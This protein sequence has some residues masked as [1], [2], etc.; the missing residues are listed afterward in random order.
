MLCKNTVSELYGLKDI[1]IIK[2]ELEVKVLELRKDEK[3][4]LARNDIKYA[5]KFNQNFSIL[6]SKIVELKTFGLNTEQFEKIMSRYK[7]LFF[8]IVDSN[9]EIGLN[10]KSGL[11]G[12][13]RNS[14]HRFEEEFK[15]LKNYELLTDM[16]TLRRNE[17]DFMLRWDLKYLDKFEKNYLKTKANVEK[18]FLSN[19]KELLGYLA[20]YR[21]DFLKFV[22][23]SEA[24]GLDEKSGEMGQLRDI[25]H[26]SDE[27]LQGFVSE[28]NKI[29]KD[30]I[31]SKV[32]STVII[33]SIT[34]IVVIL[35]ILLI[36]KNIMSVIH[37]IQKD[38]NYIVNNRDFTYQLELK[39]KNEISDVVKSINILILAFKDVINSSKI[40]SK[41]TLESTKE[42]NQTSKVMLN[43]TL[44]QSEFVET[45]H[46]LVKD[47]GTNLD[48]TE[49]MIITTAEDL[50]STKI[51]LETFVKNLTRVVSEINESSSK[52]DDIIGK[53]DNLTNG[54][55]QIKNVLT[56]IS[57]IA[58]QTN[59]LALNAAIEA[60]RAG[61]HGR[62]FAVV[63][64]EVRVLAEKTKKSLDEINMTT[65][66]IIQS[67]NDVN[68]SVTDISREILSISDS[69]SKL[70]ENAQ[71]T[72][73]RLENTIQVA[74]N[75]VR[76]STYIASKT[77]DLILSMDVL[78][79]ISNENKSSGVSI[80]Q[81]GKS[82]F[83]M[84]KKL[85]DT[86][87]SYKI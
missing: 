27:V 2:S 67:V 36:V 66:A 59:L 50:E 19:E 68:G 37:N 49:E 83:D 79:K 86:L 78:V 61:E 69:A 63:A 11:Y 30:A 76:K 40:A 60:A 54:V 9:K 10:P 15:K 3:D 26:Q 73:T 17:K 82:L 74:S 53:I 44:K 28:I 35:F 1:E 62:G 43:S 25:V 70:I 23:M 4:F 31:D 33:F 47:I 84:S 8:K 71:D 55:E 21:A 5:D 58:E 80:E 77:K 16:L 22:K 38:I 56:I 32:T 65:N 18:L 14:V 29:I 42:L 20:S 72:S 13:L 6:E 48:V 81:T 7:E 45:T 46:N 52:Q 87:E 12:S 34:L 57:D 85:E 39:S 64:D 41:G 51:V 24:I 75:S